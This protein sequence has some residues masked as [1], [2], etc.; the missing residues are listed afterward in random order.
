[1]K[2]A[3]AAVWS[4]LGD[5]N[6]PL[7]PQIF[8]TE[9]TG[10][11]RKFTNPSSE[12]TEW[13][14]IPMELPPCWEFPNRL[15]P[16]LADAKEAIGTLDGIARTLPNPD[17]LVRPL[18]NREAITSSSI[19]GTYVTAEQLL[20]YGLDPK[21]PVSDA[22]SLADENEVHNYR[23]ALTV[24]CE[25]L[26]DSPILNKHLL[27][28]HERLMFG[29]RGARKAPGE[30]RRIQVQIGATGRYV[31]PPPSD[32]PRL[33]GNLERYI[34]ELDERFDPLVASFIAHYQ[35][36][37]IHPFCDGNGRVG[38]LLLALMIYKAMHHTLPLLYLSAFFERNRR[39]YMDRLFRISTHG[40]WEGWVEFCLTG[41]VWQ[42]RDAIRRCEQLNEL[43]ERYYE[44][45]AV[46]GSARSHQLVTWLFES[47]LL[48]IPAVQ[49]KLTVT[50]PTAKSDLN[51]LVEI[52]ILREVAGSRPKTFY[53][54]EVFH[55][56]YED[57]S[58]DG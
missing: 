6:P 37:A 55:V 50:Y 12:R 44:Q 52:G 39:E 57:S 53:A 20:L 32:L 15:W 18:Q 11:L 43:R 47:P 4:R 36:E 49:Q 46:K 8:T 42:A 19:E 29:V 48:T 27:A 9:K 40:D 34:N 2:V 23:A 14:F 38:R 22:G 7:D 56:A 17:L 24:G 45:V 58:N 30:F 28:M 3:S 26:D 33:M 21:T 25:L 1:M 5:W 10:E 54:H 41:S 51:R 13:L 16:L 31:P 35:F